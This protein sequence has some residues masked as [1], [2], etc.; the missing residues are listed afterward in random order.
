MSHKKILELVKKFADKS[1]NDQFQEQRQKLEKFSEDFT[2][3]LFAIFNEMEGDLLTL[4]A[5]NYNPIQYLELSKLRKQL[6]EFYKTYNDQKPFE[7]ANKI[8]SFV[9]SEN[10]FSLIQK[11]HESIQKH[12]KENE[13]DLGSSKLLSQA[14]VDSL[15]KLVLLM[16]ST[17]SYI[18]N[19]PL[20]DDQSNRP[21]IAPPRFEKPS[22]EAFKQVGPEATTV[23]VN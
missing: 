11:L 23:V 15:R 12:L 8:I 20:I 10:V 9:L 14:K 19:N 1:L 3:K 16:Y 18:K 21:T 6:I 4:K 7:S 17:Q 2:G 22:G 5:K 13:I